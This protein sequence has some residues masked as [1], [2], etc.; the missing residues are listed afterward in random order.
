MR[1]LAGRERI[2]TAAGG[3]TLASAAEVLEAGASSVA[4]SAALFHAVD[5]A[6]EFQRWMARLA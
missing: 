3:I 2:L 5:P 6:A 4:V 1:A